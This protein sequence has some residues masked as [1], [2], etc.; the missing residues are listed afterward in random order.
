MT[1]CSQSITDVILNVSR[2][3]RILANI[4]STL[5]LS[6]GM[7]Q[8]TRRKLRYQGGVVLICLRRSRGL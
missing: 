3:T 7:Q 8:P 1:A 5:M 2:S 4:K 6:I